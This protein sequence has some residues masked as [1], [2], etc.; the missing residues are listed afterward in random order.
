MPDVRKISH[1]PGRP[2]SRYAHLNGFVRSPAFRPARQTGATSEQ[3]LLLFLLALVVL[4][5]GAIFLMG[6]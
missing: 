6:A 4:A 1:A 3:P 5:V 2:C